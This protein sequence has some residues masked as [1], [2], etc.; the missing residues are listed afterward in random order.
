MKRAIFH[1]QTASL[2]AADADPNIFRGDIT[3]ISGVVIMTSREGS[4]HNPINLSEP[5]ENQCTGREIRHYS[6]PVE[7][8]SNHSGTKSA[9]ST[10]WTEGLHEAAYDE[11]RSPP[12]GLLGKVI[13][14]S[15][16]PLR[17]MALT[18]LTVVLLF[19]LNLTGLAQEET[20]PPQ[21][22]NENTA[23]Q[24]EVLTR[25][26][27]HE[28]FAEQ[29]NNDP[30]AGVLIPNA[31]PE[32]I[33]EVP[34]EF[35][36]EGENVIWIPGYWS[37]DDEREDH[38]WVSGVWR[39]PP[40]DRRWVPGYWHSSDGGYHWVSGFWISTSQ[41]A[42]QYQ[43][44]PPLSIETGPTSAA[45]D[46]NHFWVP[47]CWRYGTTYRWRP[48]YWRPFRADWI[49]IPA[50]YI[51]TPRGTVFV[52]G[53]WDYRMPRRGQL[54]A[55]VYI[56]NHRH[57]HVHY[58]YSP[59]YVINL[60]SIGMHLF[61][62]PSYH[63][64]YFGDYYGTTYSSRNFYASFRFHGS[65]FGC[66]PFLTYYQ[67]HFARQ[68]V[69]YR[70]RLHQSHS[71]FAHHQ[72]QRPARTLKSQ[73]NII[74]NQQNNTNININVLGRSLRDVARDTRSPQKIV[75]LANEQRTSHQ[76]DV[77]TLRD[78]SS[79]R[80]D[81]ERSHKGPPASQL[82]QQKGPAKKT[83]A[84]ADRTLPRQDLALPPVRSNRHSA[85]SRVSSRGEELRRKL[86]EQKSTAKPSTVKTTP[87]RPTPTKV[88]PGKITRP[89]VTRSHPTP[90][91]GPLPARTTPPAQ[92]KQL[93]SAVRATRTSPAVKAR[94]PSSVTPTRKQPVPTTSRGSSITTRQ[95]PSRTPVRTAPA[96]K[97]RI[98]SPATSR[99][100]AIPG[101]SSSLTRPAPSRAST[102]SV[103]RTVPSSSR[104]T[105]PQSAPVRKSV[106]PAPT[107]RK[108]TSRSSS[109]RIVGPLPASSGRSTTS[110]TPSSRSSS[111]TPRSRA[112]SSSS[113]N[114]SSAATRRSSPRTTPSPR[115]K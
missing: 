5:R 80:R 54:F 113:R 8:G 70:H 95:V 94:V 28:A 89:A 90:I 46:K 50:H 34:P 26:P 15:K 98:P 105:A 74:V 25:G 10:S 41:T 55:P 62:R 101:R 73:T 66:D 11:V 23:E 100:N 45:P 111:T 44:N 51:W 85:G 20:L 2:Q 3:P 67:W 61:V 12:H 47:G 106:S 109:S 42:V 112:Q 69:N 7:H 78:I 81:H 18:G 58:R 91:V 84:Q 48:G 19:L 60:G 32:P 64:Y 35:K 86:A 57:R 104:S 24:P 72:H 22:G 96:S 108:T 38:V 13:I 52:D 6:L 16:M 71:Y 68:G 21:P 63:H 76:R 93:P 59:S 39:V 114:G 33:G 27:V 99:S 97:S 49:W 88:A 14:M 79:K 17:S 87:V 43:Q 75:R 83:V 65:G 53:Y 77:Q 102:G 37:W 115:K 92:I 31:P 4:L 1:P 110:R 40:Q 107:S 82:T 56:R 36:P 9:T 30:E 103:R 29:I